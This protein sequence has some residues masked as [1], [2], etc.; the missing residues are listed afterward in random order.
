MDFI[1][2][3]QEELLYIVPAL[4][5][6]GYYLKHYSAAPSWSIVW[7]LLLLSLVATNII[8]GVSVEAMAQGIIASAAAT[9]GHQLFKQTNEAIQEKHDR[10][11]QKPRE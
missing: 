7:I 9:L 8:M 4:W 10:Y 5:V 2:M 3:V 1:G 11:L 6:I